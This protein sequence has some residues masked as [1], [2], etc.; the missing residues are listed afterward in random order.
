MQDLKYV[1]LKQAFEHLI[2][3]ECWSVAVG[4][5]TGSMVTLDFGRKVLRKRRLHNSHLSAEQQVYRGEFWLYLENCAWRVDSESEVI[6]GS[7]DDNEESGFMV[8]GMKKMVGQCVKAYEL[9]FP[10]LDLVL[11]FSNS[12][13]LHLFCDQV[14][15]TDDIDNY[16]FSLPTI[17]YTVGPR[18]NLFVELRETLV[19]S[20]RDEPN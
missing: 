16:S 9:S 15:L 10:G 6:C 1:E 12:L 18:S 2:G 11:H 19:I 7:T 3:Q 4:K 5:G 8:D 17:L 20:K 14:N 13:S